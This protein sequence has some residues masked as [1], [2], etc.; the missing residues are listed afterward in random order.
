MG[1]R[2]ETAENMLIGQAPTDA[3]LEQAAKAVV[4]VCDPSEGLMGSVEYKT[5]MAVEMTRRSLSDAVKMA[6]GNS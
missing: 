5:A 3:L 1:V 4:D 2:A 6:G